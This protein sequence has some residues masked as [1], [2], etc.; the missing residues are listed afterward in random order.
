MVSQFVFWA[1]IAI[2]TTICPCAGATD[3]AT[4][5]AGQ[6]VA[7]YPEIKVYIE[8]LDQTGLPIET[9]QQEQLTATVGQIQA[10]VKEVKRFDQSAEGVAYVFLVDISRSLS[11]KQFAKM[12]SAISTWIDKMGASDRA[13]IISFGEKVIRVQDYTED[14]NALKN[15]V[16]SL[17][18]SDNKTQL[19]QGIAKAI[20]LSHRVDPTLPSRR[21]IVILSDGE[22]DFPG[23][24]TRDEVLA[25]MKED[26]IPFYAIGFTQQ[27]R[28]GDEKL[29]KIG[30]FARVSGGEFFDGDESD[31]PR[32]YETI[33]QKILMSF[34][35]KLDASKATADGKPYRVQLTLNS[36]GKTMTDGLDLRLL[37]PQPAAPSEVNRWYRKLPVWSYSAAGGLLVLIAGLIVR[38]KKKKATRLAAEEAQRKHRQAEEEARQKKAAEETAEKKPLDEQL[39]VKKAE[40][41]GVKMKFSVIGSSG[42]QRDY[43]INL[44]SRASIGRSLDCDL[45]MTGDEEIS[46]KHCELFIQG[47]YVLINDLNSTNGTFVNGVPVK[48]GHRLKSG[49]MIMLGRTEMRVVFNQ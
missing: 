4:F 38:A 20:E 18:I 2:I 19:H 28:A 24:M 23:G 21:A 8:A 36:A 49:D 47:S 12:Q 42:S 33:Q 37:S 27:R 5:R 22:D 17:K 48:T 14:K 30:E 26:R 46:K 10:E 45:S 35:V 15:G 25:L 31:W 6:A 43:G 1:A 9:I 11:S 32:L 16:K 7:R 39:T 44:S 41:L 29:K 34:L 3:I 13:A 40:I